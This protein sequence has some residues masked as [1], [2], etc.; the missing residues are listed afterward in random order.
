MTQFPEV[1][2][3]M[4]NLP[5]AEPKYHWFVEKGKLR[6]GRKRSEVEKEQP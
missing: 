5:Y 3:P 2:R 1:P 4:L 6:V